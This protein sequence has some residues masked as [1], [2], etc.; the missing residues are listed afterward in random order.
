MITMMF[1]M[2]RMD[3]TLMMMRMIVM[4]ITRML[5]M[6]TM[7]RMAVSKNGAKTGL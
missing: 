5:T 6:L 2:I 1:M 3:G 4:V 7:R